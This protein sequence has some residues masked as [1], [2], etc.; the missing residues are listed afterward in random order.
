MKEVVE[1]YKIPYIWL[2]HLLGAII[3]LFAPANILELSPVL[4][5]IVGMVTSIIPSI[6]SYAK[7]SNF[8]QVT[9][10]YFAVAS[11]LGVPA[12]FALIRRY[13]L[14]VPNGL[15]AIE[16]LGGL[17]LL[18]PIGG[19]L[20]VGGLALATILA[21]I[22]KRWDLM[23]IHSSRVAL[24]VLGPIFSLLP[25]LLLALAA[26]VIKTWINRNKGEK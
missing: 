2:T 17:S 20:I 3:S 24:A 6:T 5:E 14:L 16:R 10:L 26:A 13:R 19:I 7:V 9:L 12:F 8:A 25:F 21:P 23:P 11:L 1:V 18:Y 22:G 15:A 4:Q